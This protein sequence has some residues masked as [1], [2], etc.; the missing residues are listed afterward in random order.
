MSVECLWFETQRR[1]TGRSSAVVCNASK[2]F[3]AKLKSGMVFPSF[4][5][6]ASGMGPRCG[7]PRTGAARVNGV[8]RDPKRKKIDRAAGNFLCRFG[9][10][11]VDALATRT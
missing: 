4:L 10:K 8:R 6:E 5:L 11:P 9:W 2:Y 1:Q 7:R 3:V